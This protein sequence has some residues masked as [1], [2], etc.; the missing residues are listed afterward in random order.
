MREK[1][2]SPVRVSV[3]VLEAAEMLGVSEA[4]VWRMAS[5]NELPSFKIGRRRMFS[6]EAIR[7]YV[8]SKSAQVANA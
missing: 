6:V 3:G 1:Q 4:Q 7:A 2:T 8:R 5:L